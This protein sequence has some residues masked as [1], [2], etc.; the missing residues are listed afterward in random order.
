MLTLGS[1]FKARLQRP[2]IFCF[3]QI[4]L[5]L[6]DFFMFLSG[7]SRSRNSFSRSP[8]F[9]KHLPFTLFAWSGSH[10]HTSLQNPL[11][12]ATAVVSRNLHRSASRQQPLDHAV[13]AICASLLVA[14][15]LVPDT[16][17]SSIAM[18]KWHQAFWHINE[19]LCN[20]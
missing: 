3:F 8:S 11:P 2:S 4:S 9:N 7:F 17:T 12:E 18:R 6:C 5:K 20:L 19:S 1:R 16:Q 13:V 15:P 14:G 10:R